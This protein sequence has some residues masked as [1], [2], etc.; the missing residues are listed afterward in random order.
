MKFTTIAAVLA[1]FVA[2]A[3]AALPVEPAING[4]VIQDNPS[5]SQQIVIDTDRLNKPAQ[6][7]GTKSYIVVF[8]DTAAAHVMENVEKEILAFGGKIGLRY[9]AALKGFSAWI[10]GPIATALS[11]NPFIDYIEED[12][13]VTA[14]NAV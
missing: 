2:V 8:K 12:N 4:F 6:T 3:S 13:E 9:S 14:F 1:T 7:Q 10:P 11:T 5:V